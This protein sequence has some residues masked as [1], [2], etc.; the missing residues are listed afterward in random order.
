ME[1][2]SAAARC[3]GKSPGS[4]PHARPKKQSC[5][6]LPRELWEAEGS[7]PSEAS[8]LAPSLTFGETEGQ[9]GEATW[10]RSGSE[11]AGARFGGWGKT[12]GS[13]APGRQQGGGGSMAKRPACLPQP[14]PCH[15]EAQGTEERAE[16]GE[17]LLSDTGGVF[18][19]WD[20]IGCS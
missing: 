11:L 7:G 3:H 16:D 15:H 10:P 20:G 18:L 6:N 5:L 2:H 19:P 17:A 4:L 13:V 12:G 1:G 14:H 9:R 8:R